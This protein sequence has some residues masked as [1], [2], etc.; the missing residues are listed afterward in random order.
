MGRPA[1]A[2]YCKHLG[3]RHLPEAISKAKAVADAKVIHGQYIGPAQLE[4]QQHFDGP[5]PDAAHRREPL[6]DFQI[7]QFVQVLAPGHDAADGLGC[8]VA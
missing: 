8:Q 1:L 7:A 4:H 5:T 3:R 2:K 6:D